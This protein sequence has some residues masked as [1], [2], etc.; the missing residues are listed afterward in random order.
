MTSRHAQ[1]TVSADG[2]LERPGIRARV[3]SRCP[4]GPEAGSLRYGDYG[5][6]A[7]AF[8]SDGDLNEQLKTLDED[9]D[10]QGRGIRFERVIADLFRANRFEVKLNPDTAHPRQTDLI[11]VRGNDRYLIECKWRSSTAD[12]DDIDA[13]R[14]RLRRTFGATGLLISMAGFSGTAISDVSA[15]RDQPILLLSGAELRSV[16][17]RNGGLLDLL[18]RKREALFTN[19]R[20]S[21]DEPADR[22]RTVERPTLPGSPVRFVVAGSEPTSV[23]HFGGSHGQ[24]TFAREVQDIDWVPASANGVTLDVPLPSLTQDGIL[25]LLSKLA[26][27]GWASPD[28]CWSIQQMHAVW[29][30]IGAAAFA[31][32]FPRWEVRAASEQAHHSEEFCYVDRCSGGFYSLTATIPAHE[33]RWAHGAMLSFQFQGIPLDPSPVLQLCR[34]VGVHDEVYFRP[35]DAKSVN[36][37]WLPDW[38][39]PIEAVHGLVTVPDPLLERDFISGLVIPNPL[40]DPRWRD[41]LQRD[42]VELEYFDCLHGLEDPEYLICSLGDFHLTDDG[43]DYTY[44]LEYVETARTSEGRIVRLAARWEYAD[45][46]DND[47]RDKTPPFVGAQ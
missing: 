6:P 15:H 39:R 43:R 11:A 7:V 1:T 41:G 26:D 30:G 37:V 31:D 28:A 21:L 32:T 42:D 47:P 33:H 2:R 16:G 8:G 3:A 10:K 29:H 24:L 12:I 45:A 18:W 36:K 34:A 40:R 13:I 5:R 22:P 38:M 27:L 20:A 17:L 25:D 23:I 19:G 9:T 46:D 14:S 4:Q 44:A 35:R